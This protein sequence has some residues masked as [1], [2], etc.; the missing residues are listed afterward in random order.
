MPKHYPTRANPRAGAPYTFRPLPAPTK[1]YSPSDDVKPAAKASKDKKKIHSTLQKPATTPTAAA[2]VAAQP[3]SATSGS[4]FTTRTNTQAATTR[5]GQK[6]GDVA[7]MDGQDV[8]WEVE[9]ILSSRVSATT[10][11]PEYL[12][13]WHGT[14]ETSWEPRSHLND[15]AFQDATV[16][17]EDFVRDAI[18]GLH[19]KLN[20]FLGLL[21]VT[22]GGGAIGARCGSGGIFVGKRECNPRHLKI[23]EDS[24]KAK[25]G[26]MPSSQL[27]DLRHGLLEYLPALQPTSSSPSLALASSPL[28]HAG[29]GNNQASSRQRIKNNKNKPT[30]SARKTRSTTTKED[31][32]DDDD[33]ISSYETFSPTSV[34]LV[35]PSPP[36]ITHADPFFN[37]EFRLPTSKRSCLIRRPAPKIDPETLESVILCNCCQ[38]QAFSSNPNCPVSAPIQSTGCDHTICRGCVRSLHRTLNVASSKESDQVLRYWLNCPLC[39]APSVFHAKDSH[40]NRSLCDLI[41][42]CQQQRQQQRQAPPVLPATMAYETVS[43]ADSPAGPSAAPA[44]SGIDRVVNDPPGL[45]QQ[46]Q[47]QPQ[48]PIPRNSRNFAS[49]S[50]TDA[51]V[52]ADPKNSTSDEVGLSRRLVQLYPVAMTTTTTTNNSYASAIGTP[53]NIGLNVVDLDNESDEPYQQRQQQQQHESSATMGLKCT[54]PA[55]PFDTLAAS[56][57]KTVDMTTNKSSASATGT[58]AN[59]GLN[60]VD[61]VHE[62]DEPCQQ[63]QKQQQEES[64]TTMGP[65][66]TNPAGPF[67]TRAASV[68][69]MVKTTTNYSSASATGTPANIGLNVV[70]SVHESDEPFQQ[71]QQQ[72]QQQQQQQ[73]SSATIAPKCT[74]PGGPF[75][76][77]AASVVHTVDTTT[78]YS[79]ASATGT[80]ANIGLNVEDL[81]HESDEPFSAAAAAAAAG[82]GGIIG[83]DGAKLYESR[84]SLDTR[85]VSVVH[86]VNTTTNIISASVTGTPSNIS[87]NVVDLVRESDEP[88]QQ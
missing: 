7:Y 39:K 58:P 32:D 42:L 6:S 23:M 30:A 51:T 74:S 29:G 4:Y 80:P 21:T 79:S 20:E 72:Q 70:D 57:V 84:W 31:D 75:D 47:Q 12:I 44:A 64:S 66:C 82:E 83:D 62:S 54:S 5:R 18:F 26:A 71:L 45:Y 59:I 17:G 52:D 60:V 81:V 48:G 67:D 40:A 28:A 78:N 55:G 1:V 76:I 69:H 38:I 85:A 24:V 49:L 27:Q 35:T 34:S 25:I 2:A 86:T 46:Q 14:S 13:K 65:N 73:D 56:A 3:T 16:H 43:D 37:G 41:R 36:T 19:A 87:L 33:G 50:S 10:G 15:A 22:G 77:R 68:V 63:Q 11:K 53:A 61:S 88:C 9:H 8:F